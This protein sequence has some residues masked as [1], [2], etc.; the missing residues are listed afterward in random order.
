MNTQEIFPFKEIWTGDFRLDTPEIKGG[1]VHALPYLII[2]C[3]EQEY[4]L[5]FHCGQPQPASGK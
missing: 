2:G 5:G 4:Y 3:D 1:Q